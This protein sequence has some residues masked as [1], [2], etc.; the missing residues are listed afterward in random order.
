[1]LA[2]ILVGLATAWR[3][4][5]GYHPVTLTVF[6]PFRMATM[7]RGI[8]LVFVAGRLVALWRR[9]DWLGRLRAVLL[10][11]GFVGDWLL[12]VVALAELAVSAAESIRPRLPWC[13]SWRFVEP[14]VL[15]TMLALGLNFLGH[16]DTEYGNR[17][18]LAVL[19]FGLLA[20]C[21][22]M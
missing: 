20:L 5:E 10:T 3:A 8:A 4:I 12:V 11:V 14:L 17:T 1:M 13:A 19:G 16:H 22:G 18:L 7:A 21:S 6:Q 2:V 15:M 9:G